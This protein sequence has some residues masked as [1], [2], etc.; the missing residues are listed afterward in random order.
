MS[1]ELLSNEEKSALIAII[2]GQ[3]CDQD[4][5]LRQVESCGVLKREDTGVGFYY[6][7]MVNGIAY[8]NEELTLSCVGAIL[9]CEPR[10]IG[11]VLYIRAGHLSL[12]E[13][14]TY[15]GQM[16]KDW[17]ERIVQFTTVPEIPNPPCL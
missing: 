12:L 8:T 7:L 9:N 1:A 3:A 10:D 11:F 6:T 5:Y 16:P 17:A 4:R 14:F 13:G 15:V 2:K